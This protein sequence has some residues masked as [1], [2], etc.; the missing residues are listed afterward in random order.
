MVIY[1]DESGTITESNGKYFIV[2]SFTVGDPRRIS[3]AFRKWQKGKFPK[4][5]KGQAEVKFSNS[6]LDDKLRLNTLKL[7]A[8]EDIR[9]FYTFLKKQNIPKEYK[10]KGKV[11]E[12]GFLYVEIVA[13]TLELYMP[14]T[15]PELRVIRDKRTLKG[16]TAG[17]FDEILTTRL[18]PKLPAK[19]LFRTQA[20][21]STSNINVQIADWVCGALARYYEGKTMGEEFYATLK[22]NIVQEKELFSEQWTKVW[23]KK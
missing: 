3:K 16:V 12:T 15:D 21:D 4:R 19:V 1:L 20:V 2:G 9:I 22:N 8:K 7:L 11:H 6:S 5:L 14:H 13:S 18:L 23:E 17:M 10:K